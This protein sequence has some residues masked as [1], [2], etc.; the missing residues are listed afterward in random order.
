MDAHDRI[1]LYRL[2]WD[3]AA[4]AF[5]GRQ[6]LYERFFFGDPA[7]MASRLFREKDCSDAMARVRAFLC[8]S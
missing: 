6:V 8:R 3:T 4:S 5:G 1:A 7:Q 2:A